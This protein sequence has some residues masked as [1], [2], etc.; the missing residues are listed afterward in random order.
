MS[1][2]ENAYDQTFWQSTPNYKA[3][4]FVNILGAFIIKISTFF[5]LHKSNWENN[6]KHGRYTVVSG[7]G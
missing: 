3:H 1:V 7:S 4:V 5:Y 2:L 6:I